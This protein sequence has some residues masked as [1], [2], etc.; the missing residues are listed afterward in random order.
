[1]GNVS[2]RA[3]SCYSAKPPSYKDKKPLRR[4]LNYWR[5][6]VIPG[7]CDS[8]KDIG[9]LIVW[10]RKRKIIRSTWSALSQGGEAF[11]C[12]LLKP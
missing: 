5:N 6:G 9:A 8:S 2:L 3:N 7:R 12:P 4:L 10:G 11:H 1:V